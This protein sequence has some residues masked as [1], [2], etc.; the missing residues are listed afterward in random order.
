MAASLFIYTILGRL[1]ALNRQERRQITVKA[2][3]RQKKPPID[4]KK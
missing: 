2:S 3:L 1:Q 4:L